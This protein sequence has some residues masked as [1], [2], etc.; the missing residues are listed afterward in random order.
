MNRFNIDF[1][2]FS[3]LVEACLPPVP[4]ARGMFFDKVLTEYYHVLTKYERAVL[5]EWLK[6]SSK[7]DIENEHHQAF[8]ARYNPNNQYL[9]TD[10]NGD[11]HELFKLNGI[12]YSEYSP[13]YKSKW[14]PEENIK[15]VK[16]IEYERN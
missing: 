15:Q 1:F 10:I 2:E 14:L 11:T 9:V 12:Y 4:I 8:D 13:H 16:K 7:F 6:K 3:F 5:H